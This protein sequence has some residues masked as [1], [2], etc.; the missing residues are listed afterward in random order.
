MA[1]RRSTAPTPEPPPQFPPLIE[2]LI[3]IPVSREE[4]LSAGV[5][6]DSGVL[7]TMSRLDLQE[8]VP[9][10]DGLGMEHETIL[11]LARFV[12]ERA[13]LVKSGATL[14]R[15]QD[16]DSKTVASSNRIFANHAAKQAA[17]TEVKAQR[18]ATQM[19]DTQATAEA[20]SKKSKKQKAAKEAPAPK[21]K[22][23]TGRKADTSVYETMVVASSKETREGG[24]FDKVM[25]LA[26][27]PIKLE[28]LIGKVAKEVELRSAKDAE[29][30]VRVRVRDAFT[31]L[32]YLKTA[33]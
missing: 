15:L 8:I 33:K 27:N 25:K 20:T 10:T 21:E 24:F 9:K 17:K 13:L 22:K 23:N 12:V 31:R 28:T 3:S 29:T 1:K 5:Y 7:A 11:M 18:R 19:A 6:R 32:G 4:L 26:K 16:F 30:V 14:E 2:H